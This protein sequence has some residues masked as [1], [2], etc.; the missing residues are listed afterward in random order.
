MITNHIVYFRKNI[1]FIITILYAFFNIISLFSII[2]YTYRTKEKNRYISFKYK[3]E[4]CAEAHPSESS[5][6]FLSKEE[7]YLTFTF[8]LTFFLPTLTVIFAEPFFLAFRVRTTLPFLTVFLVTLATFLTVAV[9][10]SDVAF[11]LF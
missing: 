6:R 5:F 9:T 4:G 1:F 8:T 11:F 3:K 10:V 2:Y 7:N